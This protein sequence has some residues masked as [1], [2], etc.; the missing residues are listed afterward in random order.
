MPLPKIVLAYS[1][2]L[3]TSV[4]LKWL[5]E[6]GYNVT[7]VLVDIGQKEDFVKAEQKAVAIGAGK[8][9][10]IDAKKEFI[11]DFI[12][13]AIR[14]N[15]MYEGRY[16]LG[17][18][19]ARPLIAKKQMEVAKKEKAEAVSHG[20]TGKG[21][22]QV[23]FE[24]AYLTIDPKIKIVAPWKDTEFLSQFQ[25]REDMIR[26]CEKHNIPVE[27]TKA[28]PYSSDANILH[29][30][31]EAGVLEDPGF[32]PP[33]D[34]FKLTV[35][36]EDAPDKETEVTIRFE[37]G[38]PAEVNGRN[39]PVEIM[40]YLNKIGG[41]NGVGRIDIVENRFV[42]MKSRG[43]YETPAGT[44]LL[45]A[46]RDLELLTTDREVLHLK[47]TLMPK[48]AQLVYNGF[49][50]SPEMEFLQAAFDYS[51]RFVT[52]SVKAG[53]YKGNVIIRGRASEHSLYKADVASMDVH[54]NYDQRDAKGFIRLNALRLMASA[55]RLR[56]LR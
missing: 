11:E 22:D 26:Y 19:L 12:W 17:T 49:W 5:I 20:A 50:Y 34:M 55:G 14:A 33:K 36:P 47:D 54:G 3:D 38:N 23:R 41:E 25:G 40:H 9:I 43:V 37:K 30:S 15:A 31:Y 39:D 1:G 10:V 2:G 16:L 32:T 28:K 7:C 48:W 35:A 8:V 18:S 44:I 4:I 56:G 53:I 46:H 27:A 42:G 52:G 24:L 13:P 21:N 6:K 45:Q 29:I 51:Q